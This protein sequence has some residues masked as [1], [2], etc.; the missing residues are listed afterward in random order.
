MNFA[1]DQLQ[2]F[3]CIDRPHELQI[4]YTKTM[5]GFMLLNRQPKHIAMIG[6]GGGSMAKF[7]HQNLPNTRFTAI[8]INPHVIAMRQEFFIPEDSACFKVIEA[9]GA[10]F[11]RHVSD[12][13]DVLLVDGYDHKGQPVQLCTHDFYN[14]CKQA[15][16]HHGIMV[17]N[18]CENHHQY[19]LFIERIDKV[20]DGNFAE[21]AVED[22]ANVIVFASRNL[23]IWPDRLRR[24]IH[25]YGADWVQW[26]AQNA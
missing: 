8:E 2:S 20:F 24:D 18:L 1:Q 26:C 10:D 4:G 15:L 6:L 5:M 7:C 16:T 13:I 3:M 11:V 23:K 12:D 14:A 22:D 17:A 19:E 25:K 9:D 21:I